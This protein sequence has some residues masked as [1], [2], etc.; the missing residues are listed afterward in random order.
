HLLLELKDA[1]AVGAVDEPRART[2]LTENRLA[3]AERVVRYAVHVLDRGDEQAVLAEALNTHGVVLARLGNYLSAR[4][5][6][7]RAIEVAQTAGDSEGA[8]RA[9]LSLIEE[10]SDQTAP[11]QLVSIYD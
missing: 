1:G 6:L 7:Q 8:G 11:P 9:K 2:L 5:L 4:S 10:L 3:E